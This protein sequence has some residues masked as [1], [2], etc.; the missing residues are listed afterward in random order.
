[1]QQQPIIPDHGTKYVENP[2]SF[3][4]GMCEDTQMDGMG[5]F[6]YYTIPL[7]ISRESHILKKECNSIK[8]RNVHICFLSNLDMCFFFNISLKLLQL[9]DCL[10]H[11]YYIKQITQILFKTPALHNVLPKFEGFNFN[12]QRNFA[13]SVHDTLF[14]N[15]KHGRSNIDN[16]APLHVKLLYQISL[17]Q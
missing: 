4:G 13:E 15:D 5:P 9:W 11:Y 17:S 12:F 3:H 10:F 8:I 7:F 6:L 14:R 1:M 16:S 2:Y